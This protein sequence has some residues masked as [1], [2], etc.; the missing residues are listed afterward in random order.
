VTVLGGS[1]G[2]PPTFTVCP[3]AVTRAATSK[4]GAEVVLAAT[5]RDLDGNP[6]T[7]TWSVD[8]GAEQTDAI[9]AGGPPT[10]AT[11]TFTHTYGVGTHV[12][13]LALS[14]GTAP[15]VT[16]ATTVTVE[17]EAECGGLLRVSPR[18]VRFDIVRA[19]QTRT[20]TFTVRNGSKDEELRVSVSGLKAPFSLPAAAK[21]FTLA[22]GRSRTVQVRYSPGRSGK[23]A[24]ELYVESSDCKHP[25]RLVFLQGIA[26]RRTGGK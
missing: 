7:L 9:P 24:L 5:V 1:G 13:T 25:R 11:R 12:V 10:T 17:A 6:L 4:A 18:H 15:A 16:C 2:Q 19:G 21:E 26:I 22:P 8:G 23:H 20:R 14:D 3:A